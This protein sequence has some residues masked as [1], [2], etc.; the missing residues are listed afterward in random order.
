M[1]DKY[2][3]VTVGGGLGGASLARSMALE[4]RRVLVLE[5]ETEFKDR[6]RGEQLSSWG[7]GEARELGVYDLLLGT[8]ASEMRYWDVYVGPNRIQHRDLTETTPTGLPNLA[9]FHPEMQETL[10]AEA[11]KAGAE[12]RRGARV[13]DVQRGET[14]TVTF[15]IEPLA[16]EF[17]SLF[18]DPPTI[19]S[20]GLLR[21]TPATNQNTDNVNGPV[22]IRVIGR[23]SEGAETAAVE[24]QIVI[25]EVNDPP[26]AFSDSFDSDEDTVLV[27][28]SDELMLNDVDPD[29][30]TNASE[31]VRVVMPP[32]SFSVSGALVTFDAATGQITYDPSTATTL[33]ALAPGDTLKDSFA[34]S[35]I[36]AADASSNLVTV[37]LNIVGINDAPTVTL[38]GGALA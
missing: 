23:D 32:Q 25:T 13:R 1:P 22:V 36:D 11:E 15:E 19:N 33:Q 31:V 24:F 38:P 20:D 9:F 34:Y 26:R 35:L 17:A 4:G 30:L 27:I 37:A 5:R 16:P 6:V 3:I 2:D 21:F 29:L 14:P 8:C 10:V 18:V 7:S 28:R 12:V